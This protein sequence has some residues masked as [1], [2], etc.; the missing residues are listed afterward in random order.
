[1]INNSMKQPNINQNLTEAAPG[2][3]RSRSQ[4]KIQ[5]YLSPGKEGRARGKAKL[6]IFQLAKK[7]KNDFLTWKAGSFDKG[8]KESIDMEQ[9]LEY[10]N[11]STKLGKFAVAAAKENYSRKFASVSA[12]T[13]DS[14]TEVK[15]ELESEQDLKASKGD[16]KNSKID[17]SASI[18]E[19]RLQ[20]FL[21]RHDQAR[22]EDDEIDTIIVGAIRKFIKAGGKL[23]SVKS[24]DKNSTSQ[25]K[26]SSK[27]EQMAQRSQNN[28]YEDID[29]FGLDNEEKYQLEDILNKII[30][31]KELSST[32]M[33]Q[34]KNIL[35]IINQ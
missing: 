34:A 23:P 30:N 28:D 12:G 27:D 25:E 14:K 2:D 21:E 6:A 7:I 18:Y 16:N 5:R 15:P 29:S 11:T 33:R 8:E 1:M 26:V 17:T 10:M 35:Y 22:L 3:I 19:A 4:A 20:I 31:K 13:A 24:A 9:F 32:N